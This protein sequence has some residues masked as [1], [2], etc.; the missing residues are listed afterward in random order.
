MCLRH[1]SQDY[2]DLEDGAYSWSD[3]GHRLRVEPSG[4]GRKGEKQIDIVKCRFWA[5]RMDW[6][7]PQLHLAAVAHTRAGLQICVVAHPGRHRP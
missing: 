2:V 3:T 5:R 4:S 7:F 1:L 6:I